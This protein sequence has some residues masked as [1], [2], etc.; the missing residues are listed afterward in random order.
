MFLK[1]P[2]GMTSRYRAQKQR[3]PLTEAPF[4]SKDR[5]QLLRQ[6]LRTVD[7]EFGVQRLR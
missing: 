3:A 1:I 2:K 5:P 6:I 7:V 4:E